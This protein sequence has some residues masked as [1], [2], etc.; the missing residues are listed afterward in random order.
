M[1]QPFIGA[2]MDRAEQKGQKMVEKW[3]VQGKK[4]DFNSLGKQFGINPVVARIIRNRDIIT[5]E[6]YRAYLGLTNQNQ[7][8][9]SPFLFKDMEKAVS[10]ISDSINRREKIRVI[11]DY[12]IDGVCSGYILVTALEKMGADVDFDVPDRIQDG[13]GLNERLILNA[14]EAGVHL[15]ITCDNG[16]AAYHQIQKANELKMKVVVTDHHEVPY[17]LVNGEKNY[18]VPKAAA[19]IDH[20]QADCS[21]PFKELCGA[22]VAYKLV[23]AVYQRCFEEKRYAVSV[24]NECSHMDKMEFM[25]ELQVFVAIA[26]IGDLMKLTGENRRIVKRGLQTL[27]TVHNP[28]L[29][30]LLEVNGLLDKKVTSYHIS[31]VIGPCINAGGRLDTARKAFELFRCRDRQEAKQQAEVLKNINEERKRMTAVYT[32]R[33]IA[34]VEENEKMKKDAV[35]VVWLKDCHESLAGIIAG[36]LKEKYYKPAFVLTDSIDGVKGSGRS[37]EAYSMYEELVLADTKYQKEYGKGKHLL[38]KY[39]GHKMAAG[40]SLDSGKTEL[41]RQYLNQSENLHGDMQVRKIWIDVALPFEYLSETL[42]EQLELLEPFGIGNEKPVFAEKCTKVHRIKVFGNNRNVIVL[43]VENTSG[44]RMEAVCFEEE[45]TFIRNLTDKFGEEAVQ[46][47]FHGREQKL[48][49]N[50]IYYPEITEYKGFKNIRVVIKR[51]SC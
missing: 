43:T 36:K 46:A 45:E 14:Y 16:I 51:Y 31:F 47:A 19:V 4:A 30:A 48:S 25:E 50:I 28:G 20:K 26:T 7:E 40:V 37:I 44:Y 42:I 2:E 10:V 15:I 22:G 13:Y 39:G 1:S 24:E 17:E 41:F 32:E 9:E 21:Y 29:T 6:E 27:K 5:E 12:D 11:G 34:Q 18:I 35:L 49:L 3:L 23:C 8:E 38:R 33:A